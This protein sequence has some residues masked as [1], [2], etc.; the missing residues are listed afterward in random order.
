[1]AFLN[2]NCAYYN[3]YIVIP[4]IYFLHILPFHIILTLKEN[5]DP[6]NFK[7]HENE[8]YSQMVIPKYFRLLQSKLDNYCF[9]SPLSSQGMLIFGL[10]SSIFVLYPPEYLK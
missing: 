3:I 10:L 2:K 9:E 8:V 4:L 6:E 7:E 1:M 5:A